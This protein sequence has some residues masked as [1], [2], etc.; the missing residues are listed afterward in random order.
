MS[1]RYDVCYEEFNTSDWISLMTWNRI[2][3]MCFG[4]HIGWKESGWWGNIHQLSPV[5]HITGSFMDGMSFGWMEK[6]KRVEA[7]KA[8]L[9]PRRQSFC[10]DSSLHIVSRLQVWWARWKKLD[11]FHMCLRWWSFAFL[12]ICGLIF[13]S[14]SQTWTWSHRS[15]ALTWLQAIKVWAWTWE[16]NPPKAG[17]TFRYSPTIL[18]TCKGRAQF[19]LSWTIKNLQVKVEL[20]M[21]VCGNSMKFI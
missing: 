1:A 18:C 10:V 15:T 16:T 14:M 6:R 5:T 13:N 17:K 12:L 3:E 11:A 19:L 8:P 7:P 9:H 2:I 20:K 4:L 21:C